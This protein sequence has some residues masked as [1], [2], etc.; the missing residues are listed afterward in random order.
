M[1]NALAY[2]IQ[3]N[4]LGCTPGVPAAVIAQWLEP[5]HRPAALRD[6][7]RHELTGTDPRECRERLL[8]VLEAER[9][10]LRDLDEQ[11]RR[12]VDVPSLLEALDCVSILT[13]ETARRLARSQSEA[14]ID[15][16]PDVEG[17]GQNPRGGPRGPWSFVLCPLSFVLGG[18]RRG[19]GRIG[20]DEPGPAGADRPLTTETDAVPPPACRQVDE[21][22]RRRTRERAGR[23]DANSS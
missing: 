3:I 15:V 12:E 11:V 9:D 4:N 17:A 19:G 2:A 22:F 8:A 7:P 1:A 20:G 6:R 16:P 10:R 14:R 21:L 13:E 18:R 5:A 23:V